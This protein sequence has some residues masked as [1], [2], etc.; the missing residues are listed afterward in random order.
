[1]SSKHI[2][3]TDDRVIWRRPDVLACFEDRVRLESLAK[4]RERSEESLNRKHWL[5]LREVLSSLPF[6]HEIEGRGGNIR[7]DFSGGAI[8]LGERSCFLPQESR[9]LEEAVN[10]LIPWRK[11]P[12]SLFG[13]EIDSEWR[14]DL[15]WQ[16]VLPCLDDLKQK[17]VLDIGC[18]NGYYMLRM[19]EQA[20]R[21]V[22]GIDPSEA[23]FYSFELVQRFLQD[24]RL[25]FELLGIEDVSLF[26]G[27]FDVVFC[28]GI[29]YHQRD[30]LGCLKRVMGAMAPSAMIVVESQAIQGEEPIA[31]FPPSRYAKARNVFFVPTPSCLAAWLVRSGFRDVKIC[32][33]EK[34]APKEQRRTR[35]APYESLSDFL[36]PGDSS[37]TVEGFPAP[38]RVIVTGRKSDV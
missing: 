15:K 27:F 9:L 36:A 17:R 3:G 31:L 19:L 29:L 24:E 21:F 5:R 1:M 16:R 30:P 28:M 38:W 8:V 4:A 22:L 7:R 2:A 33:V 32:S 14:S 6:G 11:G 37:K 26:D 34:V 23:F 10:L 18:G 13:L 35:L 20:P 12:F 25:Q